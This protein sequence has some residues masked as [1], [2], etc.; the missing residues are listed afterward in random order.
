MADTIKQFSVDR[1]KAQE[2]E[3]VTV[4]WSCQDT[5]AVSLSVNDGVMEYSMSLADSGS[6]TILIQNSPKGKTVLTLRSVN[7][8][9]VEKKE[10]SVKVKNVETAKATKVGSFQDKVQIFFSDL[11][12]SWRTFSARMKYGWQNLPPKRKTFFKIILIALVLIYLD[13]L[14]H[15]FAYGNHVKKDHDRNIPQQESISV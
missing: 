9:K 12:S 5:E 14:I 3:Y 4:S 11:K 1:E 7:N 13:I 2:G 6:R 10:I 8:G 15:S